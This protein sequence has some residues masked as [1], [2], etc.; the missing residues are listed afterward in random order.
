MTVAYDLG[1]QLLELEPYFSSVAQ[2]SGALL[3]LVFVALTFNPKT[4][5]LRHDP[6]LRSLAEQVFADFLMVLVVTLWLLIPHPGLRQTGAVV[7]VI[8]V[9]GLV[10]FAR[11]GLPLL[12]MQHALRGRLLQRFWLSLLGNI[13]FVVAGTLMYLGWQPTIAWS[14]LVSSPILLL[15]GG[16]RSAWLLVMHTAE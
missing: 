16:A 11:S 14:A 12:R 6:M 2:V 7:L 13:G 4:P 9:A 8:G 10:R 5:G 15:I 3:G 1:K